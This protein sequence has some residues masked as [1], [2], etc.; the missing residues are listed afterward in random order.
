MQTYTLHSTTFALDRYTGTDGQTHVLLGIDNGKGSVVV[1]LSDL[2]TALSKLNKPTPTHIEYEGRT[3][4][5][6]TVREDRRTRGDGDYY[7]RPTIE[8]WSEWAGL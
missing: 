6:P 3:Y 4:P 2:L 1:H 7:D 8:D 5:N